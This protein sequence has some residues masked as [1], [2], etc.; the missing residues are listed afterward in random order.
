LSWTI[1]TGTGPFAYQ[2]QFGLHGS[3]TFADFFFPTTIPRQ[4]ITDLTPGTLYDFRV[5]AL[6]T[7]GQGNPSPLAIGS[8]HP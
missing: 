5:Y 3:Q 4:T 2:V 6:N 8:T 7:S 1:P